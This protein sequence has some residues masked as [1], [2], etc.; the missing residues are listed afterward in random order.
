VLPRGNHWLCR[1][2]RTLRD[3]S[4]LAQR[5]SSTVATGM[6]GRMAV[7][8]IGGPQKEVSAAIA[9]AVVCVRA[10]QP[11]LGAPA[12]TGMRRRGAPYFAVGKNIEVVWKN[13]DRGFV[14][15][16]VFGSG[17]TTNGFGGPCP[18]PS[19]ATARVV[20]VD[21][22]KKKATIAFFIL[23]LLGHVRTWRWRREYTVRQMSLP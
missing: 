6:L 12:A 18:V 2:T 9:R 16:G 8:L 14:G 10:C 20:I 19:W 22:R 7:L 5:L 11:L 13:C 15:G 1:E 17:R 21:V 3:P 4:E 23:I